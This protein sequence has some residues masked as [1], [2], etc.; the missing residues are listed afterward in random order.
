MSS[1]P[2]SI[3]R[4]NMM[5]TYPDHTWREQ[6][7]VADERNAREVGQLMLWAMA[8]RVPV[9]VHNTLDR[10]DIAYP[11]IEAVV[12]VPNRHTPSVRL[13]DRKASD[14]HVTVSARK[15]VPL[16]DPPEPLPD[17]RALVDIT[18]E[19]KKELFDTMRSGV[20]VK[21]GK[22][23]YRRVQAILFRFDPESGRITL[24][25]EL[26]RAR[27]CGTCELP[28]LPVKPTGHLLNR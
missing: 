9:T 5:K 10:Y 14:C 17:I 20:T 12:Y 21:Y 16:L 18:D 27:D 26:V 15:A 7:R 28:Q 4:D 8:E 19:R 13:R 22:V 25:V 23:E 6:E 2:L 24:T 3:Q 1:S 11:I